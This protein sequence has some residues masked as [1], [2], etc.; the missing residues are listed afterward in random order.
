MAFHYNPKIVT[1]GLL[2]YIDAA[3]TKSYP[4]SGTTATDLT[5][6]SYNGTLN[7]GTAF[8]TDN[9]GT[10]RFDGANDRININTQPGYPATVDDAFTIESAIYIPTGAD[11]QDTTNSNSG[12]GIVG[13]GG[14]SGSIGFRRFDPTNIGW[15]IRPLGSNR[16]VDYTATYDQWYIL[17]GT[18]NGTN[19]AGGMKFYVNGELVGS[20]TVSDALSTAL[21]NSS[22]LIGGNTA[23]GGNTGLYGQ[24]DIP[25]FRLYNRALTETEAKQNYNATRGRFGL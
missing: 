3:N 20:T 18:F 23:F 17:T 10:W 15:W 4:G 7:S 12:T 14:Y 19:D 2:I 11:W 6:N 16:T 9:K 5:G 22:W 21:D 24:G 13:R 1:D 8:S 25:Y